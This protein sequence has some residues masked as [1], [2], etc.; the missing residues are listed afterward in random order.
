MP[1]FRGKLKRMDSK[2]ITLALDDDRIIDFR[3]TGFH[4]VLQGRRRN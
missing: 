3:R 4:Q 1:N 2:T